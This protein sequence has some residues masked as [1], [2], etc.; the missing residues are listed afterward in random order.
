MHYYFY[1][2]LWLFI[3]YSF[4][5]WVLETVGAAFKQKKFVNRGLINGPFC[6]IYGFTVCVVSVFFQEL[7]GIWLFGASFITATVTEWTAGWLIGKFFHE[8]WWDYS[9]HKWNLDGYVCLSMSVFWGLLCTA[10]VTWG[11]GL[12]LKLYQIIPSP[13]DNILLWILAVILLLDVVATMIILKGRSRNLERWENIDAWL[14]SISNRLSRRIYRSVNRRIEKAYPEAEH[15]VEETEKS[16][17]FAPGC[18]FHK[19]LWLF[20][21][22]A[23]LGDITETIFCRLTA[24]VWMSRSSVVW[25]PFSIVWGLAIAAATV[26]LYKYKNR[27]DKFIFFAGTFLGGAYEYICSVFTEIVFGQIFWD[28]S[29]MPFN[30]GGR[31]NLLYCFFWGIAA[32]VWIKLLYPKLSALIERVPVKCGKVISY[33]LIVFMTCNMIVSSMAMIRYNERSQGISPKYGWQKTM[34]ERFDD[35]RMQR[36]Y[37]NAKRVS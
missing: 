19:I 32:V 29:H 17:V 21:I 4:L 25:G 35:E 31:I 12:L 8:R 11:N 30:L 22:G 16:E 34:D 7:R 13:F 36:I 24:G 28:Y 23:F 14:D 2:L 1:E 3:I 6:I 9:G 15:Q 5:G 26:L 27:S 20:M 33:L 18:G 10:A 37:P